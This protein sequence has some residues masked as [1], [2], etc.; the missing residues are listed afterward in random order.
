[1]GGAEAVKQ[2][3]TGEYDPGKVG[4]SALFGGA[5]GTA[6]PIVGKVAESLFGDA[7][8]IAKEAGSQFIDFAKKNNLPFSI[9]ALSSKPKLTLGQAYADYGP[10]QLITNWQRGKLIEKTTELSKAVNDELG[11]TPSIGINN[12]ADE[13]ALSTKQLVNKKMT[14]ADWNKA[15]ES[16][17]DD[18]RIDAQVF[19]ETVDKIG[20]LPEIDRIF[21]GESGHISRQAENAKRVMLRGDFDKADLNFMI[22]NLNTKY[23]E[24][25]RNKDYIG[26]KNVGQLKGAIMEDISYTQLPELNTTLAAVRAAADDALSSNMSLINEFPIIKKLIGSSER[27]TGMVLSLFNEG[28]I[29]AA[30]AL[31]ERLM[32]VPGGKDSWEALQSS[33]LEK[34]F[35]S[36]LVSRG[37]FTQKVFDPGKYLD[38]FEKYGNAASKIMPDIA[39]SLQEWE[40]ISRGISKDFMRKTDTKT[41]LKIAGASVGIGGTAGSLAGGPVG[42]VAIPGFSVLAAL[43]TMGPG[44]WGFIRNSLTKQAMQPMNI[45][46]RLMSIPPVMGAMEET[47]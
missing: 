34:I 20:G 43:G 17:P 3:I 44:N 1:M 21:R 18:I 10:G 38:W 47:K 41:A 45:G 30:Q 32:T 26:I 37:D 36:T 25:L 9:D 12:A 2:G 16:L 19:N 4:A 35:D 46:S 23:N 39:P 14:H 13:L 33:Y 42:M 31:R 15:F 24:L 22:N 5:I 8:P 11:L 6:A 7:V 28:N 40:Q 27:R 29:P